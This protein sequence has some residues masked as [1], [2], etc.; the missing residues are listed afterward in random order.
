[1]ITY[2]NLGKT[3]RGNLGNQMFQ[4]ASTIGLAKKNGHQFFF[5]EWH[6]SQYFK[7]S[8]PT[9]EKDEN[10]IYIKEEYYKYYDWNINKGNYDIDGWLQTEKYFDQY[11]TKEIFTFKQDFKNRL[12]KKFNNLFLKKTILISIRRGDFVNN[13]KYWQLSYKYYLLALTQNFPDWQN[14]NLIFTSDDLDYCK[15]HFSFLKNAFFLDNLSTIEQLVIGSNCDDFVISNST[16][17]WWIAWLGEKEQSKVVRPMKNFSEKFIMLYDDIDYYPSRWISF[18]HKMYR[19][20]NKY[21]ILKVTGFFY[22]IIIDC[23]SIFW[24]YNKVTKNFVKI[25]F[26]LLLDVPK[27]VTGKL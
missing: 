22:E 11:T 14:R 10:F 6:Y 8:L 24:K 20:E 7:K 21:L 26:S 3:Y 12:I 1:M 25:I 16:F 13:P 18:D 15:F 17:S 5:P 23:K 9:G 27:K 4:I 2:S 19:I